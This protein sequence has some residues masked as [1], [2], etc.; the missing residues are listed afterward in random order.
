MLGLARDPTVILRLAIQWGCPGEPWPGA[1]DTEHR[2]GEVRGR[3]AMHH[4]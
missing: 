3:P 1:L 2:S 4:T